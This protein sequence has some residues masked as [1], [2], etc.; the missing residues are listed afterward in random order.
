MK[1]IINILLNVLNL[2]EIEMEA[3]IHMNKWIC[4]CYWVDME[5]T[6]RINFPTILVLLI[7]LEFI[8]LR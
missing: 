3:F 4:T 8:N 2:F 7:R 1:I 6:C 5:L